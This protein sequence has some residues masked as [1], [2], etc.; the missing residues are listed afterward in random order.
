MRAQLGSLLMGR[1]GVPGDP[2]MPYINLGDLG[3]GRQ[4]LEPQRLPV[5][6]LQVQWNKLEDSIMCSCAVVFPLDVLSHSF[7]P[8]LFY[9]QRHC[10]INPKRHCLETPVFAGLGCI[11][12]TGPAPISCSQGLTIGGLSMPG[13]CCPADLSSLPQMGH[14]HLESLSVPAP[15]QG[16]ALGKCAGSEGQKPNRSADPSLHL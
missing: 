15:C 16:L 1:A 6:S 11:P 3:L 13:W 9:F 10:N 7:K 8:V 12:A 2:L 4:L 5:S 14:K